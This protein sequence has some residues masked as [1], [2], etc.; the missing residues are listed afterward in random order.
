ME[1]VEPRKKKVIAGGKEIPY[2]YLFLATGAAMRPEEIPGLKEN[3]NTIWTPEEMLRLR[4]SLDAVVDRANSGK[5]SRVRFLV[6]PIT[7]ARPSYEMVM[8][9]DSWLQ[10]KRVRHHVDVSYTTYEKGY[11]QAFGPRLN[12]VV[13]TEFERRGITGRKEAIVERVEAGQGFLQGW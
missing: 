12:D 6:P 13:T 11:I 8:M 5:Q 7:S 1:A 2:D 10:K 4:N 9:L 3:A